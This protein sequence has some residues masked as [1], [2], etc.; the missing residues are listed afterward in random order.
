MFLLQSN[1]DS[2]LV[3]HLN[4]TVIYRSGSV[5]FL[6]WH[7][8]LK[9]RSNQDSLF[10][11]KNVH[12]SNSASGK[13]ASQV[14]THPLYSRSKFQVKRDFTW[15]KMLISW[16]DSSVLHYASSP[17]RI[18]LVTSYSRPQRTPFLLVTWPASSPGDEDVTSAAFF[19]M[20]W[21]AMKINRRFLV[22]KQGDLYFYCII[23]MHKSCF[24]VKKL[25][26]N[27]NAIIDRWFSVEF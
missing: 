14:S 15:F 22:S 25:K 23:L 20:P 27:W 21:L 18:L 9:P 8:S 4:G 2:T 3:C 10:D 17:R 7:H 1:D 11:R 5:D 26:K 13:W 6:V 19:C 16:G 12:I 24:Y